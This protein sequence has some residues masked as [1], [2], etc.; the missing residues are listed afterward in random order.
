MLREHHKGIALTHENIGTPSSYDAK[1]VHSFAFDKR[2]EAESL[3][4]L[5]SRVYIDPPEYTPPK[6]TKMF[7]PIE[8]KLLNTLLVNANSKLK[9]DDLKTDAEKKEAATL[10][11]AINKKVL[12]CTEISTAALPEEIHISSQG[13]LPVTYQ[14]KN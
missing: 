13:K 1:N 5:A 11:K 4:R 8:R 12:A 6:E 3:A 7:N 14:I 2:K 10:L 9:E